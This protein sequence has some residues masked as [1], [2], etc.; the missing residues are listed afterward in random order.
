MGA[1]LEGAAQLLRPG[2]RF[3]AV[4][5]HPAFRAP[6]Q[7]SWQWEEPQAAPARVRR[8]PTRA[9]RAS[10]R[11]PARD[12]AKGARPSQV[13]QYR[14]VDAYL[15]EASRAIVMNPGAASSG[16][17]PVTTTTYHRPIGAYVAALATAGFVVDALEEWPSERTSQPG[18]RADEENRARREI[19]L[20]LALRAIRPPNPGRRAGPVG[21]RA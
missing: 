6:G 4:V 10:T 20:F 11:P 5:L 13:R 12:Q 1:V 3:V 9:S 8:D 2:G 14:R 21:D 7:T 15:S 19:P 18:A 17:A 16:A